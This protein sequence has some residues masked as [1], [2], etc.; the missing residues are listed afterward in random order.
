MTWEISHTAE[1][2]QNAQHNLFHMDRENLIAAI[3]DDKFEYV[4]HVGSIENASRAA[5]ALRERIK[6]LPQEALVDL[7]LENIHE[8]MNCSNGGWEFYID[9][10]GYWTVSIDEDCDDPECEYLAAVAG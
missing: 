1:A 2:W 6:E 3:T 4:E 10:E 5:N 7:A 8:H 9:R